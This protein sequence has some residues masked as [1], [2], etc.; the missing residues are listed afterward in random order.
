MRLRLRRPLTGP[1][2]DTGDRD[3]AMGLSLVTGGAGF[4]GSHIAEALVRRGAPVRILD[5]FS[6]GRR[7]NL[8]PF[9]DRVELIEGDLNDPRPLADAVRGVEVV[10]HQAALPSV[11]RSIDDP[12]ASLR[13]SVDATAALLV[14]ARR[15]GVRRLI[16]AASSSAYGNRSQFPRVESIL[17]EPLSPYAAGKLAAE[18]LCYVF[19]KSYGLETVS[20][21]YFNV[22]GPRQDPA[23]QYAAAIPLFISAILRNQPPVIYGDGEQSRDFTYVDNVVHANLL[24]AEAPAA[25]RKAFNCGCGG[26]V[27]V[28]EVVAAINRTLGTNVQPLYKPRRPGD[29]LHSH[30]DIS[31]ARRC[32]GYEPVVPFDEGLRRTIESLRPR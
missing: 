8:E 32:L 7:A 30:A 31:L 23:S 28:N 3:I 2:T 6:T 19:W 20:L 18:Y 9:R 22:F 10:F 16:Y 14:A 13:A 29:V 1:D 12:L 24:A 11:P 17:P 25:P 21:R 27:T 26:R 4:I 5:N 15:A